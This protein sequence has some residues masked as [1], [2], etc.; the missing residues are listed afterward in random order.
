MQEDSQEQAPVE[1]KEEKPLKQ[2][3]TFQG[4]IAEALKHE[5]QSVV[6]IVE[7]EHAKRE[8]AGK[9]SAYTDNPSPDHSHLWRTALLILGTVILLGIGGY[10]GWYAYTEYQTK[11]ALPTV[12]V[13]ANQLLTPTTSFD[14]N[15]TSLDRAGLL[16]AILTSAEKNLASGGI[17]AVEV[18]EGDGQS[19]TLTTTE[20][21]FVRYL[22]TQAPASLIRAF[23]PLFYLGFLGPNSGE[24]TNHPFIL[25]KLDSFENAFPGMLL[26]E[27]TMGK[28]LLPLI[29]P[30]A[31]PSNPN[32]FQDITIQN[33][34]ARILKDSSG[35]TVLLYSFYDN[36]F[37]IITD[38][39]TS[40]RTLVGDLDAQ[41][42]TR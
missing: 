31:D 4:D 14:L 16:S 17:E 26:W 42:V 28:D 38:N 41:K 32:K 13:P 27:S 8:E 3:R 19:A 20:H 25:V 22:E 34:D 40:L 33:K 9:D 36:N 10:G 15:V 12:Y 7:R 24:S 21:F 29:S 11:T 23:D 30:T 37:L 39:E 5:S 1:P 6:S 18:R 35:S 2:I